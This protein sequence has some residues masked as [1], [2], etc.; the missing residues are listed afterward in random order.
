[1]SSGGQW[2]VV[3]KNKKTKTNGQPTKLSR[4]EKKKFVENAPKAEDILPA[5][6]VK[7]LYTSLKS[8]EAA[9]KKKEAAKPSVSNAKPKDQEKKA[10]KKS[11]QPQPEKKKSPR[12][13][14]EGFKA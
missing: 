3:V 14:E 9:E 5:M 10:P 6:E 2:E 12:T 13:M 7:T 4:S 11:V 8:D 1:M